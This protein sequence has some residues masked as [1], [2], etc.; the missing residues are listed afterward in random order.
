MTQS[1]E[2]KLQQVRDKLLSIEADI[3]RARA[4]LKGVQND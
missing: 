4:I 2:T 1:A 3:A